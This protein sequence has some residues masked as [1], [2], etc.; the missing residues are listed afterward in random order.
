MRF[1]FTGRTSFGVSTRG[2][3]F[4]VYAKKGVIPFE[5][6]VLTHLYVVRPPGLEPGTR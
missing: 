1:C 3:S 4:G 5:Y 2:Y 6:W